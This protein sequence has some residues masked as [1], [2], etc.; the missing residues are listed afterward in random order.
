MPRGDRRC[1]LARAALG[2]ILLLSSSALYPSN[3]EGSNPI[4]TRG[5]SVSQSALTVEDLSTFLERALKTQL[6]LFEI[7]GA[8]VA[9]V[10]GDK[11]LYLGGFGKANL[12]SNEPVSAQETLF[13]TGSVSKL[14]TWTAVMQLIEQGLLDLHADVNRYLDA[15]QIP[16]TYRKPVT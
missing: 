14:V 6:A 12:A 13:R 11:T 16:A 3:N 8:A 1:T 4:P 7:P 2:V 9:V 5:P 10:K 15:L